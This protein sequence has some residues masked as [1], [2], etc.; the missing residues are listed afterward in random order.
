MEEGQREAALRELVRKYRANRSKVPIDVLRTKYKTAYQRIRM[1]MRTAAVR[2]AYWLPDWMEGPGLPA[3]GWKLYMAV[4]ARSFS[5]GGYARKLSQA[6]FVQMDEDEA[7]RI[8]QE[9]N[10]DFARRW[11][12]LLRRMDKRFAVLGQ[13]GLPGDIRLFNP[14]TRR[15][16]EDGEWRERREGDVI[17]DFSSQ[18]AE[19]MDKWRKWMPKEEK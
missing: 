17:P 2:M 19:E 3:E 11:E 9:A 7:V 14:V 8:A 18:M 15:I 4:F 1:E 10:R 5:E 16:C 6:L 12:E 13:D